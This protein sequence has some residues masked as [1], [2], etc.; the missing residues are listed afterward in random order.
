MNGSPWGERDARDTALA[1]S[2]DPA[3]RNSGANGAKSVGRA[4]SD[5]DAAPE[6][7]AKVVRRCGAIQARA[8]AGDDKT[9]AESRRNASRMRPVEASEA[10]F[11]LSSNF[12]ATNH[13]CP[14]EQNPFDRQHLSHRPARIVVSD[15]LPMEMDVVG[16]S[17]R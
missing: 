11:A 12:D 4:M 15:R 7:R 8:H 16:V 6:G 10:H 9:H 2:D 1:G 13:R 17:G 5:E 3:G 14:A